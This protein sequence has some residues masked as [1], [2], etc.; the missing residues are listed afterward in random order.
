MTPKIIH[1]VWVG[2]APK[3]PIVLQCIESWKKFC[4]GWEIR[5]WGNELV[6]QAGNRYAREALSQKKWAFVADWARLYVLYTYGGFYLDTDMEIMKPID[7]FLQNQLTM[8]F[9]L[10]HGRVFYNGGFIGCQ[11]GHKILKDLLAEYDKIPFVKP[12]GELDQTTNVVRMGD[13][14][15]SRWN[16]RPKSAFEMVSIADGIVIYPHDYFLSKNGYTYHHYCASWFDDWIRK[17]CLKIGPY[18]L[19]RFKQRQGVNDGQPKL[20]DN[21]RVIWAWR[22]NSRKWIYFVKSNL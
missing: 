6:E 19:I 10:S 12:D 1:F 7:E 17:I 16:L 18:K 3:P 8:G 14:F 15:A 5:E 2:D 9:V 13:Y 11:K 22:I 20:L 21:E 4:P